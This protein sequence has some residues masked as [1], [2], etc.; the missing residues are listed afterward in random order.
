MESPN[1]ASRLL[2]FLDHRRRDFDHCVVVAAEQHLHQRL[3]LLLDRLLLRGRLAHDERWRQLA[4]GEQ[5]K[6]SKHDEAAEH[7]RSI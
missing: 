2:G 7:V 4:N 6:N 5:R 3:A 1:T